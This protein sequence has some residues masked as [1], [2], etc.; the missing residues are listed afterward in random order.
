MFELSGLP[1]AIGSM[2]HTDPQKACAVI[3]KYLSEIP[4][5]PQ[6]SQRS[7]L[8]NMYAQYS[9]GF[10]GVIIDDDRIYIDTSQGLGEPLEKFYTAYLEE[11][12]EKF[13][14]GAEYAAGLREFLASKP[15]A[16]LAVKGQ[17]TGPVTWGLTVTD[18]N[19]R[20]ILYD[21]TLSDA[22]AKHLNM[23]ARWQESKLQPVS[24]N[25][26]IF[27]DEPYMVSVG[28][29]FVSLS[30]EQVVGLLEEAF[31]GIEGLKGVHCC[32]NTDWSILTDT[33][34]DII[35]FDAYNYSHTLALYPDAMKDFIER[36]GVLAWGIVPHEEND[37]L[38][39]SVPSL[40][41][42]LTEGMENL[43]RKGIPHRQIVE[44]CLLTPSCGLASAS[45]EAAE[46]A[47]EQLADLSKEFRI[48][49][50]KES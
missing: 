6:L 38:R 46:Q 42:R 48:R 10:P 14:I 47:L 13:A 37:L 12:I 15:G 20:P 25:T 44:Q 3:A 39:E 9:E 8:E 33:L 30:R 21:E 1:T 16:P 41:D 35:N 17:V 31:T 45:E 19:R 11:D 34:V 28:S 4:V 2:P 5:W 43:E 29:A 23:K 24:A 26:I 7:F 40:I 27:F 36:G 32:G 18:E 22:V 50:I 49:Y